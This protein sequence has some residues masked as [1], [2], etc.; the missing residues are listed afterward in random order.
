MIV[1]PI[2]GHVLLI[3]LSSRSGPPLVVNSS[4]SSSLFLRRFSS[5]RTKCNIIEG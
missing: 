2:W 4:L 1:T 3:F 5:S